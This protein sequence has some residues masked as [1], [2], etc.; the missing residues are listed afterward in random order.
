MSEIPA[1]L[2]RVVAR[3][4]VLDVPEGL[5]ALPTVQDDV[6][7]VTALLRA[8]DIAG[9]GHTSANIALT[10]ARLAD[11]R[12]AWEYGSITLRRGS[13]IVGLLIVVDG[14]R[15]GEGWTL[16]VA[17]QPGDVRLHAINGALIDAALREGRYRWDVLSPDPDEPMPVARASGYANDVPLRADLE[18]RG[19]REVRRFQRMKVDHWSVQ[20]PTGAVAAAEEGAAVD[21]P[22]TSGGTLPLGC[23][24][25]PFG[26][27]AAD[28][29]AAHAVETA[30]H[31]DRAG[32]LPVSPEVWRSNHRG[33]TD[34]PGQWF[35]AEADGHV[36]GL[37][38]GSNRYAEEDYGCVEGLAVLPDHQGRGIGRALLR[39][40]IDDDINRGMLGTLAHVDTTQVVAGHLFRSLGMVTDSDHVGFERPL[41][42]GV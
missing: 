29:A 40:C 41:F 17:A 10:R 35:L 42:R 8:A 25:R 34:D 15:S 4:G 26:N 3:A 22:E 12:T 28:W 23:V 37:G 27:D 33:G 24:I 13:T 6:E 31:G 18:Q 36:V 32:H 2:R 1:L 14:L 38:M 9:C 5:T 30:A 7:A 16:D 21:D 39:A 19:F 20:G 11:P